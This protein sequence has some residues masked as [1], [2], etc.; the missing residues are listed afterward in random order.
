MARTILGILAGIACAM[1]TIT[2]VELASRPLHPMPAG[3]DMRDGAAMIAYVTSA[4]L[5]LLVLVLC[6]WVLGAFNGGLVAALLARTRRRLAA[7][8]VGAVVVAGVAIN[9]MLLPHPPWM[10]VLGVLLPLAA[11]FAASMLA[12]RISGASGA[13]T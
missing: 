12:T 8:V 2:L 6:G 9:A 11:A 1:V 5:S 7:L 4:P 13:S 3:Q 10:T